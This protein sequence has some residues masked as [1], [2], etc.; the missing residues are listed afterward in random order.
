MPVTQTLYQTIAVFDTFQPLSF[1]VLSSIIHKLNNTTCVLDPFP[2]KVLMSHLSHI[3][4][5]QT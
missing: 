1:D 4:F 5:L 2:T 3:C